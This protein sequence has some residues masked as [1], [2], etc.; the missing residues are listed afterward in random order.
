MSD[1]I[2]TPLGK[3]PQNML[4][5]W[6]LVCHYMAPIM[7]F[8]QDP[9]VTEIMINRFDLIFI[10][11]NEGMIK[12]EARFESEE[13]LA[14]LIRQISIALQ[15]DSDRPDIIDARFPDQSRACCI[16]SLVSTFGSSMTIRCAPKKKLTFA[17]LLNGN[18]LTQEMADYIKERVELQDNIVISGGT[19]SGKTTLIRAITE[20]IPKTDRVIICEDTQELFLDLPNQVML[21]APKRKDS[22]LTLSDLIKTT[23]R[24][25]PDRVIVGEIRDAFACDAYLQIL[26]TGHSGCTTSLHANSPKSAVK[27][28]QYLLAKEGIIDFNLAGYEVLDAVNLLIQMK[29][30]VHGRKITHISKVDEEMNIIPVFRYDIKDNIYIRYTD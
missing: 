27:R 30:T 29:K 24:M 6:S 16:T 8:Y 10:E 21:E 4:N 7:G 12:T 3:V 22:T 26:N 2:E 15:Q 19:G 11:T 17:D 13:D 5:K 18:A 1:F 23:L 28:I 14:K 25:R 9:D 20:F